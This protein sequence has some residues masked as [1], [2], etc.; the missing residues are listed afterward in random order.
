MKEAMF[1]KK[2]DGKKIECNLCNHRCIIKNGNRGICNIRE[3]NNGILYSLVYG[4]VIAKS[5]D[6]I[7][8]KPLFHFLPGSKSYSIAT[9]GC[10]F[11]C[12][13]CQNYYISQKE[14]NEING[15][16]IRPEDIVKNAINGGCKSIAYTYT[17][18]TIFYEYAYDIAKIASKKNL[19]NIFVTN[20]YITK[21]ALEKFS[22]YLDAAN[23]DLK[24]MTNK[25]YKSICKAKL[26]HVLDNIKLFYELGIWIEITTLII[27]DYNDDLNDLK[28]I[29]DFI[30]NIDTDIPWHVTRF[31]PD[32]KLEKCNPTKTETLNNIINIGKNKGLNY[33]Y[34]GNVG[35]GENTFCPKCKN[36]IIKRNIFNV[37]DI[38]IK[39]SYCQ[40]C[41]KNISGIWDN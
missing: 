34:Q 8:K 24:G 7:E 16:Y 36:L 27:P 22:P 10:N 1:Y 31:H 12:L 39:T 25:F 14:N 28:M 20:G 15:E 11:K 17:E 21:E 38:K 4:K 13:H 35:A 26:Q 32:Y 9:E 3:N 37:S 2:L 6:P 29:V 40:F 41:K 19:K 23:I 18:P 33:I 5:I 30:K